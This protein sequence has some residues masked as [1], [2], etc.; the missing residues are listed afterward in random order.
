MNPLR[1]LIADDTPA[2]LALLAGV[3]EPEGYEILT[4]TNGREA[5]QLAARACPDLVLLDVVMPG[6]DGFHVCRELKADEST[7]DVPVIFITSRRDTESVLRGFRL[8]AVDYIE[9]P[10]QAE[11]VVTRVATHLKVSRLTRELQQ[12]NAELEA[13]AER[14][15]Q[16]ER[17]REVADQRLSSL[18]AQE[19]QRWGLS[20]FVGNSP[21][22]RRILDDIGRLQQFGKTSVLITGESGTGKE[23]VA[24]AIHH[25][26]PRSAAPF[27]PVNCVA[28]PSELAESLFFGHLKGAFTG[29]TGDRKG[30]FELADGG[31]LFL[32]EIGDMPVALQAKLLRVIEDGEI[33]PVGATASRRVDVRVLGA[34]NADLMDRIAAGSFRQDLYFRLARFVV[35]TPPLRDRRDDLPLLAGHFLALFAAEM[36]LTPPDLTPEA[37]AAL[38][39][40]PFPGNVRELKNAMERAL[41]LCGGRPVR[42]EHLQLI[43]PTPAHPIAASPIAAAAVAAGTGELPITLEAA[44]QAMIQRALELTGGNVAEAARLLD[45]NRSRIYRKFPQAGKS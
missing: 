18:A 35:T 10:F 20:G 19:A 33:T 25:H 45:I 23:L 16:A 8:G 34:T 1:V 44:E 27:I 9:K 24:R 14:R 32:D 28:I 41:I 30:W 37:L 12:R 15:R 5:L 4:A 29:A 43:P 2:S 13:E 42:R 38:A 31:T 3:L 11:E 22:L 39:A 26:S 36:G 40:H 21:H 17:A 6:H 7:R